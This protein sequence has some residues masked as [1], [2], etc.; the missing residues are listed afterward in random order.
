VLATKMWE[1]ELGIRIIQS[2]NPG[3]SISL[4]LWHQEHD[5]PINRPVDHRPQ[6]IPENPDICWKA[7]YWTEKIMVDRS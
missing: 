3:P 6:D 4:S 2:R 7:S 5:V 1:A